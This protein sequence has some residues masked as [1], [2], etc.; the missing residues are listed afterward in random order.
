[1]IMIVITITITICRNDNTSKKKVKKKQLS[2]FNN[3]KTF[4][5][6]LYTFFVHSVQ[7]F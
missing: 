3:L 5:L 1:M 2:V 7:L 6:E 4:L